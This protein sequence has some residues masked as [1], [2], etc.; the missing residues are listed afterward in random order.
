MSA[1]YYYIVMAAIALNF[2]TATAQGPVEDVDPV[3]ARSAALPTHHEDRVTLKSG[4]VLQ[5]VRVVRTTPFKLYLEVVPSVPPLAI[6]IK[7]VAAI[8]YGQLEPRRS[9][10]S[11][12]E[13]EAPAEEP[14]RVMQAVKIS[15]KLAE[16]M[17]SPISEKDVLFENQ[18]LLNT[19]RSVGILSGITVTFGPELERLS[20][21]LRSFTLRLVGG[22][23]F[24][25][26]YRNT[27]LPEVTWLEM[28]YRFD[29]VYFERAYDDSLALPRDG[30][31][32]GKEKGPD[33]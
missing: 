17:A 1:L 21:E 20:P 7:Q 5:G 3:P 27:L 30:A 31:G 10:A 8:T 19:L 24:E 25:E 11:A 6:P 12:T 13:P 26:F 32:S 28:E 14:A 4:K 23:S 22:A 2:G 33:E 18:D 15:P 29:T 9:R 16:Q